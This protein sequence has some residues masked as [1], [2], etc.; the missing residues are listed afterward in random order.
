MVSIIKCKDL[1]YIIERAIY[2]CLA[3]DHR[4]ITT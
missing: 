2:D 3:E 4:I 1:R